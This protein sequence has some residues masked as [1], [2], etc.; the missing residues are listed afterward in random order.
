MHRP[1]EDLIQLL[2]VFCWNHFERGIQKALHQAHDTEAGIYYR[3]KALLEAADR[4]QYNEICDDIIGRYP[5]GIYQVLLRY[6]YT[7]LYLVSEPTLASWAEHKRADWIA[8][9]LNKYCTKIPTD[10]FDTVRKST[11]S[12]EQSHHKANTRGKQVPLLHAVYL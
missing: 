7:Y 11:N 1:D 4:E 2:V 12:V 6:S 5:R 9:G 10:I 3:M 8:C